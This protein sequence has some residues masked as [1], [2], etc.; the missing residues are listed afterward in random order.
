MCSVG[1]SKYDIGNVSWHVDFFF[2]GGEETEELSALQRYHGKGLK[3]SAPSCYR[4]SK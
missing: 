3:L 4:Q 1:K 2:T